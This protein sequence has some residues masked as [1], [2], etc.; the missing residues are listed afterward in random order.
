MQI[1]KNSSIFNGGRK[2]AR[3]TRFKNIKNSILFVY[4]AQP[5]ADKKINYS[6]AI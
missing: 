1:K 6:H 4:S 2:P 3:A 5:K